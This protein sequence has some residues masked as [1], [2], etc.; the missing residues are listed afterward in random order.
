MDFDTPVYSSPPPSKR[1]RTMVVDAGTQT[2]RASFSYAKPRTR[3]FAFKNKKPS[4]LAQ[5]VRKEVLKTNYS[6]SETKFHPLGIE[7]QQLLHN[8][9]WNLGGP[10]CFP[11]LLRTSPGTGQQA[12]IGDSVYGMYLKLR[13]WLSNKADRTNV[14][15]RV[16]VISTPPNE[17]NFATPAIWRNFTGNKMLDFVN[18]D[19]YSVVYD[20]IIDVEAGDTSQESG[21]TLREISTY[22]DFKIPLNRKISYQTDTGSTPVPKLQRDCLSLCIIPYDA[23]GTLPTDIVG[24]YAMGG[25]FC[26]KDM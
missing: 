17:V 24:S 3:R 5:Q 15:Y 16:M 9:G 8:S 22:H 12:R 4:K 2:S 23:F 21:A 14:M 6:L 26:Y 25:I 13:L 20:T 11:N 1:S 10:V 18:S 19:I 7:N